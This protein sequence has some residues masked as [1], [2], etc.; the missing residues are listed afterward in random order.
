MGAEKGRDAD[1]ERMDVEY[2]RAR[3]QNHHLAVIR[4]IHILSSH[5]GRER[6]E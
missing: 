6:C 4:L 3:P 2:N 1:H 5:C